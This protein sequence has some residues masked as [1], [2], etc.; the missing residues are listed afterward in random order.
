ML[1]SV[2]HKAISDYKKIPCLTVGVA[3][4][5]VTYVES[6]V[7]CTREYGDID[8]SFYIS[9]EGVY[10]NTLKYMIK[11]G[12]L[13]EFYERLNAIVTNTSGI[14]WGGS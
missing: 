11:E 4:I 13:S 6:G 12:L 2:A 7:Q 14:R 9:M 8:G 5:M 3:N 1:A 10:E